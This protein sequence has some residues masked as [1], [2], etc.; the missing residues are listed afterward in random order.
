MKTEWRVVAIFNVVLFVVLVS[1]SSPSSPR[2]LSIFNLLL[3]NKE[4]P[5][6]RIGF[7]ICYSRNWLCYHFK[8]WLMFVDFQILDSLLVFWLLTCWR[9][10]IIYFVGCCARRNA[11][12]SRSKGW[13]GPIDLQKFFA[14]EIKRSLWF[15]CPICKLFNYCLRLWTNK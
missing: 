12:R 1:N 4:T 11:A 6:I 13:N 3:A 10:S 7:S 15:T 9:Q 14:R 2:Q 5:K 8:H